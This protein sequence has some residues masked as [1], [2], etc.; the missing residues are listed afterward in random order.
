MANLDPCERANVFDTGPCFELATTARERDAFG[1]IVRAPSIFVTGC[2]VNRAQKFLAGL[3]CA[4][5][6]NCLSDRLPLAVCS[7]WHSIGC[8]LLYQ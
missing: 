4:N 1:L 7:W 5:C 3:N 8:L 2:S 6:D